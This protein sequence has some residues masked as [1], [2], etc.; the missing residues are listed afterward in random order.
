MGE[1]IPAVIWLCDLR[2]FSTLSEELPREALIDLLNGYFGT[3]C[4]AIEQHQGE[5]LKFIGDAKQPKRDR[6]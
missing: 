2:G 3:M 6:R 1:T 4:Q 5:V